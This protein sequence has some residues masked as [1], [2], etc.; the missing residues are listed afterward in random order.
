MTFLRSQRPDALSWWLLLISASIVIAGLLLGSAAGGQGR[1]V[2]PKASG[3]AVALPA[4]ADNAAADEEPVVVILPFEIHSG[5]DIGYL[6]ETLPSL[7]AA[8]L[9]ATGKVT[10]VD[11]SQAKDALAQEA[12]SGLSDDKI[13]SLGEEF[14]ARGIVTASVTEL[15][16]RYSL[17]EA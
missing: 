6:A 12:V 17:P 15:A 13:R 9:Q 5:R 4:S 7:L 14:G 11:P 2:E 10:V 16:G 1:D 8:R 3:E